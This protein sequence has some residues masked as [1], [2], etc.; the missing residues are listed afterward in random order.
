MNTKNN[1][2]EYAYHD[3][4]IDG[5]EC[6]ELMMQYGN[7]KACCHSGSCDDD[8]EAVRHIPYIRK[9]LDK[10]SNEQLES[11]A[12]E[13][14]VEFEEYEGRDI[15]RDVLEIYIVWL[16][17]GDIVDEVYNREKERNAA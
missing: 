13:Y 6:F 17:A 10:L 1:H 15:P 2:K 7:A 4:S 3:V 5:L 12:R 14:G 11:A 16:S 8:C 9:Q